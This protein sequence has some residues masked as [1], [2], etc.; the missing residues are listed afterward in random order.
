MRNK[1][2]N[3]DR[4][5]VLGLEH[6]IDKIGYQAQIYYE[7]NIKVKYLVS[8]KNGNSE[9]FAEK[10]NANIEVLP[11]N[12][13]FIVYKLVKNLII[14]KPKF[15]EIYDTGYM[16]LIYLIFSALFNKKIIV[17]LRGHELHKCNRKK[18]NLNYFMHKLGVRL[19]YKYVIK[20]ENLIY[21]YKA[22]GFDENK[23]IEIYNSVPM[24]QKEDEIVGKDIDLLY[25]NSIKK[26]RK[27]FFLAKV[28]KKVLLSKPDLNVVMTG[29]NTLDNP[30]YS[31]DPEQEYKTIDFIKKNNLVE[32]IQIKGFVKNSREYHSRAKLF[33][34]PTDIVFLNYSLLESMSYGA[35]P[36][37][38]AGE[39]AEKIIN[40]DNGY[41]LPLDE[42]LWVNKIIELLENDEL[43]ESKSKNAIVTVQEKFS[44]ESWFEKMM[45]ARS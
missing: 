39:G 34:F 21:E 11:K 18:N 37:V 29:F 2:L 32:K 28:V 43:R 24:P 15:V 16:F 4:T 41:I 26:D 12:R 1:K 22:L 23:Y 38:S 25:L 35:V 44:M 10:Y 9:Y 6:F 30:D 20:E 36:I 19:S 31:F 3:K 5:L 33:L 13:L 45:G 17:I 40:N 8:N 14:Y 42:D 7:K 27:V